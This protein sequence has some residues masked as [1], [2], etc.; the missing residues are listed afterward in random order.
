MK[1]LFSNKYFLIGF[2][3]F[4]VGS[5]PL[6]L[7]MLAAALGMTS[8]PNPNPIYFGMMAGL[9][10]WPSIILMAIGVYKWRKNSVEPAEG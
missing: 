6:I 3:L 9:T 4:I 1:Q 5:S 8:D 10:F 7:T 2:V